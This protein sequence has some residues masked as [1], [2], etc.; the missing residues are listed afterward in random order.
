MSTHNRISNLVNSQVPFF[1]RNDHTQFVTF[2]EKYYE[3][4]EQDTKALDR[5]KGFFDIQNIDLTDDEFAEHLYATF[6]KFIPSHVE[7][8]KKLML[9]HIKDFYRAKG[10]EKSVRFLMRAIYN[11]EISFYYPKQDVLKVSDGKWYIQKSIRVAD[12]KI[13]GVANT[14]ISGLEKY[15]STRLLGLTSNTSATVERVERFYEQGAQI[16]ELVLSNIDGTFDS[17]ETILAL[18]DDIEQTSNISSTLF[19]GLINSITVENGGTLYEVGDPVIIVSST[20]QGACAAV[21]SVTT[22]NVAS[23]AVVEGGAGFQSNNFILISGGGPGGGGANAYISEVDTSGDVHPNTYNICSTTIDMIANVFINSA[24]YGANGNFCNANSTIQQLCD[25]WQYANTGPARTVVVTLG[26]ENYTE[27]PS[28]SVFANTSILSL[29]ILGRMEIIEGGINY[30]IGDLIEFVNLPGCLGTGASANVTNVDANGSI[31]QVGWRTLPGHITGGA[32]YSIDTLPGTHLL[33]N[34]GTGANIAVTAILGSGEELRADTSTIGSILR[35]IVT[36]KG[37]GYDA[38]TTI[39]LTQSGDGL[40]TA[41]ATILEGII[42]YPGR[43]LNDDGHLSSYNFLQDRDYYQDFSYVIRS[44]LSIEKYRSVMKNLTHPA[45]TKLWGEYLH[46]A[47]VEDDYEDVN[48][49]SPWNTIGFKTYVKTGNTINVAYTTNPFKVGDQVTLEFTSGNFS[50]VSNGIYTITG[51]GNNHILAVSTVT[52]NTSGN[53]E[54]GMYS[55]LWTPDNYEDTIAYW[56]DA[57]DGIMTGTYVNQANVTSWPNKGTTGGTAV[58]ANTA[59]TPIMS[60]PMGTFNN[61][62]VVAYWFDDRILSMPSVFEQEPWG[63]Y[64]SGLM[65]GNTYTAPWDGENIHGAHIFCSRISAGAGDIDTPVH[66]VDGREK[67]TASVDDAWENNNDQTWFLAG[68]ISW[69]GEDN[70]GRWTTSEGG[71]FS[72]G[73]RPSLDRTAGTNFAEII[74]FNRKLNDEE[75]EVIEGYLAWKY[76]YASRLPDTHQF[77]RRPPRITLNKM[78]RGY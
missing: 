59:H 31:T 71:V 70:K 8:D 32:G 58:Q 64:D 44:R 16:D 73:N 61:F 22:G 3:Y 21:A 20:G 51:R 17:G 36:S 69:S 60:Y 42:T 23:I 37:Q 76:N 26:G 15:V 62:A 65:L 39:D 9:K 5:I 13:N 63:I 68:Y 12:T 11:A 29:G 53:V 77:K 34:T 27:Q 40:A 66:R 24:N 57:N 56:F 50:N 19:S 30:H 25:Y 78:I 4:L 18:F 35:I 72:I 14:E 6:M 55:V 41:N 10:T 2:L 7:T 67:A 1:V 75:I 54:I 48:E 52:G 43:W 46:E 74:G 47:V 33:S 45:G 38:N 28:F 49:A